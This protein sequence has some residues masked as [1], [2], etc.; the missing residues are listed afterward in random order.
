MADDL[1]F[2]HFDQNRDIM[3]YR[4]GSL[5][6]GFTLTGFDISC[7]TEDVINSFNQSISNFFIS[8]GEGFR[9]QVFIG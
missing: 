2:W 9:L 1:A 5:G 7:A 6:A 4:D 8:C 3:V